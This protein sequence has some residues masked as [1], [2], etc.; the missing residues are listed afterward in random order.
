MSAIATLEVSTEVEDRYAGVRALWAKVI[1][2]AMY[3]YVSYKDSQ[4]LA[5]RKY[6]EGAERWLFH[7]SEVFNSFENICRMLGIRPEAVRRRALSMTKDEISKIE[8]VDRTLGGAPGT[9]LVDARV[10]LDSF[11]GR[12]QRGPVPL[13]DLELTEDT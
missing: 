3:D 2:R 10:L 8:H 7:P 1:I 4:K 12:G 11:S 9:T 13:E 5:L 6:A